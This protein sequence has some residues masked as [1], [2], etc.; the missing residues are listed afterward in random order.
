M[1]GSLLS[2]KD[3]VNAMRPILRLTNGL[4]TLLVASTL[5][6][7]PAAAS[8]QHGGHGGGHAGASGGSSHGPSHPGG[9]QQTAAPRDGA[10]T[11][12]GDGKPATATPDPGG[13]RTD[14][15]GGNHDVARAVPRRTPRGGGEHATVIV[16]RAY[17]PATYGFGWSGLGFGYYD[18]DPFYGPWYSGG[19]GGFGV[20]FLDEG[21]LRLKVSPRNAEVYVD[22]YYA[23]IVDDFDGVFQKLRLEAGPHHV[24]IR[25]DGFETLAFDVRILPDQKTTY[26]GTLKLE[27]G[28]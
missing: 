20:G 2:L 8:A 17:Y 13:S 15:T 6:F 1:A 3:Q 5:S 23:G 26:S 25:G 11:P 10:R 24:E 21:S 16:P 27:T 12:Q 19:Y 14:N 4:V 7:Y 9:G 28:Q 22:G 18:F